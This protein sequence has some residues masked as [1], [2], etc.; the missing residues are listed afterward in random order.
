MCGRRKG[1]GGARG[2]H[3]GA[4]AAHRRRQPFEIIV[5][6]PKLYV[7]RGPVW[8]PMLQAFG[9]RCFA[10][11]RTAPILLNRSADTRLVG[12]NE[13]LG[14]SVGDVIGVHS[15]TIVHEKTSQVNKNMG[16]I[17]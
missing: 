5:T 17:S 8:L 15:E 13:G 1:S 6:G 10:R 16:N 2:V 7:Q 11:W 12:E 9:D 3:D 4:E 14:V